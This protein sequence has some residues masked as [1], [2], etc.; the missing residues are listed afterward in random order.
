MTI[1]R[2]F[3]G[4]NVRNLKKASKMLGRKLAQPLQ[5]YYPYAKVINNTTKDLQG[6]LC[7]WRVP[8]PAG[9]VPR[10]YPYAKVNSS[11]RSDLRGVYPPPAGAGPRYYPYAKNINNAR[12]P[13]PG[14][15]QRF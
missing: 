12:D 13:L 7:F 8:P 9:A 11:A 14:P 5:A 3:L 10:Y 2:R 6:S 1:G 4:A 15:L